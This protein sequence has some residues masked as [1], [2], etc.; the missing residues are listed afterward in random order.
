MNL[1]RT[2][3][4]T[5]TN[6][7]ALAVAMAGAFAAS[8][9]AQT[10]ASEQ[11]ASNAHQTNEI[12]VTA[13]RQDEKLSKVPISVAAFTTESLARRCRRSGNTRIAMKD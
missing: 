4:R 12:V 7:V 11:D 6:L 13:T 2:T 8:A 9:H 1:R 10:G 3:M 5:T